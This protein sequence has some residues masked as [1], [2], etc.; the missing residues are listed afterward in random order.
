MNISPR[1]AGSTTSEPPSTSSTGTS[2]SSG[3]PPNATGNGPLS[4]F[5]MDG[6]ASPVNESLGQG[7]VGVVDGRNPGSLPSE[8]IDPVTQA[9]VNLSQRVNALELT[10]APKSIQNIDPDNQQTEGP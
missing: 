8:V 6:D 5:N 3:T 1:L 9:S 7:V 10:D 4:A 2:S